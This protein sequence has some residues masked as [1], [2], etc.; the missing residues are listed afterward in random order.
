MPIPVKVRGGPDEYTLQ[1]LT[2]Q[3][4]IDIAVIA[5]VEGG[6]RVGWLDALPSAV[7][8]EK[9][10][11]ELAKAREDNAKAKEKARPEAKAKAADA[12]FEAADAEAKEAKDEGESQ[13]GR[14]QGH[15]PRRGR[16]HAGPGRPDPQPP[17]QR[18]RRPGLAQGDARPR[19][20]P[21]PVPLRE[22]TTPR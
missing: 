16:R 8:G 4:L 1:N 3:K 18:Q 19:R 22:P 9:P 13:E 2:G 6:F 10:V 21:G 17:D 15:A 14:A 12:V 5:P 7:P 20:R 11:D